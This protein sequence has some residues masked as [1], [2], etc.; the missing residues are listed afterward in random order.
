MKRLLISLA[1]F[2]V[3]IPLWAQITQ[4]ELLSGYDKTGIN[5]I[6]IQPLDAKGDFSIATSV[7]F[8]QHRRIADEIFDVT[9]V[10]AAIYWNLTKGLRIGPAVNFNSKVGLKKKLSLLYVNGFG[11]F[12]IVVAPS[13]ETLEKDY[14]GEIFMEV[15]YNQ[16][17]RKNWG[18][19]AQL[20]LY[21]E[22]KEF[23]EH[24][25]SFQ[26]LRLGP[27]YKH[28]H[29]GLAFNYDKYGPF[30]ATTS[31]FGIFSRISL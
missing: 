2:V 13:F 28:F 24:A 27:S 26:H 8:D 10:Q 20:S 22:L 16:K 5:F 9:I 11:D 25:R 17:F 19:F 21:I 1:F 3:T 7:H 30:M 6:S 4:I 23:S 29:F 18:I 15:Q 31:T 14:L 12:N